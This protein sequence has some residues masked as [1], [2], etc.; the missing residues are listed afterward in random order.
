MMHV[1]ANGVEV[2]APKLTFREIIEKKG[3]PFATRRFCCAI[4]K[5]YKINKHVLLGVRKEESAKRSVYEPQVCVKGVKRYYPLLF[6]TNEDLKS[7]ANVIEFHPL[8]YDLQGA[9][10]PERRL[11]CMGCP[12][13]SVRHRIT[14]FKNNPA[15]LHLWLRSGMRF[16]ETHPLSKSGKLYS[17]VKEM[18]VANL[19]RGVRDW[20]VGLFGNQ[21][22]EIMNG[23]FGQIDLEKI[24]YHK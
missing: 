4:L 1:L 22:N 18:F 5:E 12:L 17:D 24:R 19:Y 21:A 8:Y 15:L 7:F 13:A 2:R 11:G 14:E 20:N 9:F 10:H 23:L 6:F 3:F 16:L